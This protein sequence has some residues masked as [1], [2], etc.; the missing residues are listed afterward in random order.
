MACLNERGNVPSLKARFTM[1][2]IGWART[3]RQDL[4]RKVGIVSREQDELVDCE[5]ALRT[6]SRVAGVK[7]DRAFEVKG[8]GGSDGGAEDE[9][10]AAESLAILPLKK[11][12]KADAR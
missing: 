4:S 7:A 10:K 5:M 9:S 2:V 6:S 12:R 11:S 1:L 3:S 8:K